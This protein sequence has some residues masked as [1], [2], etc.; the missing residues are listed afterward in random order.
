MII[1]T[2]YC[3][4]CEHIVRL[5]EDG[6]CRSC[7]KHADNMPKTEEDEIKHI[8]EGGYE[9]EGGEYYPARHIDPDYE[10]GGES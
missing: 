9:P 1:E 6:Y 8:N 10:L 7:G 4:Y 2:K 3:D 5:T